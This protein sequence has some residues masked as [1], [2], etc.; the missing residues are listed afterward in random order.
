MGEPERLA[1]ARVV[2]VGLPVVVVV[3]HSACAAATRA[4]HLRPAVRRAA[5]CLQVAGA[6]A[7]G[8]RRG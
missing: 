8:R 5:H 7:V 1:R 6:P 4:D 3:L 2:A